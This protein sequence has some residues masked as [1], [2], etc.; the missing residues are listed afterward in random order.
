MNRRPLVLRLIPYMGVGLLIWLIG[1]WAANREYLLLQFLAGIG[2][3]VVWVL[4][5]R[6]IWRDWFRPPMDL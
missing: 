6:L 3:V 4:C 2:F 1:F 5:V